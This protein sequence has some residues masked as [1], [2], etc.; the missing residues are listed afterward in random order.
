MLTYRGKY[1]MC[2]LF[3]NGIYGIPDSFITV[4]TVYLILL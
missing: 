2:K 1:T 3:Y 4:F